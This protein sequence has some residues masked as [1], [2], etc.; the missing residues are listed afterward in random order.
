MTTPE[1]IQALANFGYDAQEARFL[2]SAALH[3]GYFLRRQF[4]SFIGWTKG[5][6][7]MVLL[8]KIKANRHC[9]VTLYRHDR[10]VFHLCAKPLYEA[11]GEKDNRNRR[12]HQPSTIKNKIMTL[13]F[14]L[15]HP[16]YRYL[17]T[18]SEKLDYFRKLNIASEDLPVRWYESPRGREA[19]AKHFADKYP[20]FIAGD[21]KETTPLVHFCYVDEG[22][23]TTGRFETYLNQY[24]RLLAALPD[25][26]VI[27]IAQHDRLFAKA[28]EVF[29]GLIG[30]LRPAGAP[31]DSQARQLLD[32]FEL[33]REYEAKDF[34]RFNTAR[35]IQYRE[36]RERFAAKEYEDLFARWRTGGNA[37]VLAV[38]DPDRDSEDCPVDRFSTCV[39]EH[40]YDLFGTLTT[41][42]DKQTVAT[43]AQTQR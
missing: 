41:G 22:L 39:L 5:W 37:V 6:K 24:S 18:E 30:A 1:R 25:F 15:E 17:A 13:D 32:Y 16:G 4:L 38:H 9:R 26:R 28:R 14:V 31:L 42:S 3:S 2:V 12:E 35:L 19:C 36:T 33:R 27:Y 21:P 8:N 23:Q 20:I 29:E 10:M 40:D 7:D 11:L 43:D 34:V